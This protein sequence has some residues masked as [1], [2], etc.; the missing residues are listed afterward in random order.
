[1]NMLNGCLLQTYIKFLCR[2]CKKNVDDN[3]HAIQYDIWN[4]WVYIKCNNLNYIDYKYL[5]KE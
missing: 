5:C 4:F 2:I 1:M 3:D